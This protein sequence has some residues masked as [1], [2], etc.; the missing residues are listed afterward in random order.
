MI[1]INVRVLD[2]QYTI[3]VG[4]GILSNI[5]TLI[6]NID[7]YAQFVIITD[8]VVYE[9]YGGVIE[10]LFYNTTK[11]VETIVIEHGE[12]SKNIDSYDAII[13]TMLE[14]NILRNALVIA[15]GGGMIGDL[16]GFVAAT[17]MRGVD[18]IQV[19]TT[20]LAH[21]SS[22]GGKVAINH[23]LGK[24]TMGAFFQPKAVIYDLD[25]LK[26][27]PEI[28][29]LSGFGEVLK[30]KEIS[31]DFKIN[32]ESI[33]MIKS[34]EEYIVDAIHVKRKIVEIDPF[35]RSVRR[36]LNY[37]HT[38]G[39]ALETMQ[40]YKIPHG[41]CVLYGMYFCTLLEDRESPEIENALKLLNHKLININPDEIEQYLALVYR[42]K[43]MTNST[44]QF[45]LKKDDKL[46][47]CDITNEEF[48]HAFTKFITKVG[49]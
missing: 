12:S 10:P 1:E 47:M 31:N 41:I 13:E 30:H 5:L 8:D 40:N 42:D 38:F 39:H 18:F 34:V 11:Q 23:T 17:Y 45:L 4:K 9:L 44:I 32:I 6:P 22:V 14:A 2:N 28:E 21:D 24:N 35:E 29:W 20:L 16:A 7:A 15:F 19:P 27:L 25:L 49:S 26:T 3:N 46:V 33:S 48:S 37:G 43:K 36:N